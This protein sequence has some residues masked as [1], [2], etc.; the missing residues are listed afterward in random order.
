M[1]IHIGFNLYMDTNRELPAQD[2]ALG[3]PD[4]D[5]RFDP[6]LRLDDD[7]WVEVTDAMA[8]AGCNTIV[9]DLADGIHYTSHPEIAVAGA[10]SPDRLATELD[11]LRGLGL[12]PI[13]K[14]NFSAS[15]DAWMGQY[16]RKVSSP[17]YYQVCADLIAEVSQLFDTPRLFH[18][19]MDEETLEH[20]ALYDYV[21]IRQHQLWWHDVAFLANQVTRSGSRP[22]MWAD[23]MWRV[24]DD[25]S[26]NIPR[27][28]VQSSWSYHNFDAGAPHDVRRP[29]DPRTGWVAYVD[30]DEQGYDQIVT[31]SNC[32]TPRNFE[33]TVSFAR[34]HLDAQRL[35]GVMHAPWVPTL[36]QHR[37]KLLE[38]VAQV[39][40]ARRELDSPPLP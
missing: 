16:A 1:L 21:V 24:P 13:P 5:F 33:L 27:S 23:A 36:T 29:L 25:F 10:W 40:E 31:G 20:Q 15:H 32:Y 38:A 18:L 37:Q 4:D 26:K 39:S 9:L 35:L 12:E 7:M 2:Q 17:E 19:G 3:V 28:I 11:R 30:L 22:W 8:A 34:A 14:L 6:S